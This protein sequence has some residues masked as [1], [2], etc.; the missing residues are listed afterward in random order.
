MLSVH[1]DLRSNYMKSKQPTNTFSP[2][3]VN[4]SIIFDAC[5]S[6]VVVKS[7]RSSLVIQ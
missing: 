3:G 6:G 2:G 5:T 4:S 1:G 7:S